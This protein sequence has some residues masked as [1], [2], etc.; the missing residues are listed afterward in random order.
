ML[1]TRTT[2]LRRRR[3]WWWRW[4]RRR[5]A[6]GF[7]G[8]GGGAGR[9]ETEGGK[10][11]GA[12]L[13]CCGG[14]GIGGQ[15]ERDETASTTNTRTCWTWRKK[16]KVASRSEDLKKGRTQN[17]SQ[18]KAGPLSMSTY[19][20]AG[21]GYQRGRRGR[22]SGNSSRHRKG[23]PSGMFA[24]TREMA[25]LDWMIRR[26]LWLKEWTQVFTN[27]RNHAL[28]CLRSRMHSIHTVAHRP[29]AWFGHC[30]I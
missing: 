24:A 10:K 7:G 3:G 16:G 29:P 14:G 17:Q 28:F 19:L 4:G 1:T 25:G 6:T 8:G 23:S 2:P 21:R 18:D 13:W 12:N 11:P 22:Y 26:K 15:K 30:C 27:E 20:L 9:D 5:R